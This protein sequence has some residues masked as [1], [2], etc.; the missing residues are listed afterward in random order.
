MPTFRK[1]GTSWRAE[2]ARNGHRESATEIA[3]KL[4]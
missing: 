3:N 4:D 1:R 2:V